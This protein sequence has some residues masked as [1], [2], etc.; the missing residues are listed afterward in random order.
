[1][2]VAGKTACIR[3]TPLPRVEIL[4]AGG[5]VIS[6][7]YAGTNRVR[8]KGFPR[9]RW[10]SGFSAPCRGS[11]WN[12]PHLML[13]VGEGQGGGSGGSGGRLGNAPTLWRPSFTHKR[14]GALPTLSGRA[15]RSDCVGKIAGAEI[16]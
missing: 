4:A 10:A 7:P 6:N 12:V 15:Y 9:C 2:P 11:P 1:D 16:A 14:A 13:P 8:F 5:G 3:K